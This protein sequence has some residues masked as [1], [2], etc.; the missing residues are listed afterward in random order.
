MPEKEF[1]SRYLGD[2]VYASFVG[3]H[4][5]LH[6]DSHENGPLIALEPEV[7]EALN[8]YHEDLKKGVA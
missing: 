7:L 4:I 8:K 5:W 6:L 1:P 3:Y 2:V